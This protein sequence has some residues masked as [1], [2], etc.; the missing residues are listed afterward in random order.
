MYNV[1][2]AAFAVVAIVAAFAVVAIVD[3]GTCV[4]AILNK[5]HEPFHYFLCS[6]FPGIPATCIS[7]YL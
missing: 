3:F 2:V 1:A 4:H 5:N 7:G 6:M